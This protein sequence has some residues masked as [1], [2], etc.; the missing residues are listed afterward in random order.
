MRGTASLVD[1][2]WGG[3]NLVVIDWASLKMPG[4]EKRACQR[5]KINGEQKDS[6]TRITEYRVAVRAN[7]Q[8]AVVLRD[9]GL[10]EEADYFAY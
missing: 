9:Q 8:L 4:D 2:R 10:N 1:V 7:R 5:K 6:T 3:V